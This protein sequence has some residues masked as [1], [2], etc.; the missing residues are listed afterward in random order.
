MGKK[1]NTELFK[2]ATEGG[3]G[4]N[5]T[6]GGNAEEGDGRTVH[7]KQRGCPETRGDRVEFV[8]FGGEDFSF[9]QA[10]DQGVHGRFIP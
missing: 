10:V 1:L 3:C 7:A 4:C 6:A 8:A 9:D 5:D 2:M